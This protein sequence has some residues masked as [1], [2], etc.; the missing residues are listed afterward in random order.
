[1]RTPRFMF[2][3]DYSR[4]WHGRDAVARIQTRGEWPELGQQQQRWRP[5]VRDCTYS[6]GGAI[7][8]PGGLSMGYHSKRVQVD[9]TVSGLRKLGQAG[10]SLSAIA[11]LGFREKTRKPASDRLTWRRLMASRRLSGNCRLCT[12]CLRRVCLWANIVH[13]EH[14]EPRAARAPH[15]SRHFVQQDFQIQKMFWIPF[16]VQFSMRMRNKCNNRWKWCSS[17][18]LHTQITAGLLRIP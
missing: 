1:M 14:L 9:L 6:E 11:G 13:T 4:G 12:C 2:S 7:V 5:M 17:K 16:T 15:H 10:L 3:K 8:L 18:P